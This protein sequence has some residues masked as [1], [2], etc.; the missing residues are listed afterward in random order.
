MKSND[1]DLIA[2]LLESTEFIVAEL[3]TFELLSGDVLRYTD[4]DI[5]ITHSGVTWHAAPLEITRGEKRTSI[6]FEVDDV[7]LEIISDG[8]AILNGFSLQRLMQ[9]GFMHDALVTMEKLY[10][11]QWGT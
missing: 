5:D 2:H 3:F 8:T 6:G 9:L 7:P 11:Q 1:P 10:F 4:A